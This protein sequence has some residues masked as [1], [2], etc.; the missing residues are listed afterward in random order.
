MAHLSGASNQAPSGQPGSA[1]DPRSPAALTDAPN[2]RRTPLLLAAAAGL[3]WA[4]ALLLLLLPHPELSAALNSVADERLIFSGLVVLA[5]LLTFVPAQRRL[6]L[7]GLAFEGTL[8]LWLLLYT[9]AYVPPPTGWLLSLPD[10]P[11]YLVFMLALF[12]TVAAL[13]VPLIYALGR[14]IFSQRARQYD[15]RRAR[16]Q[17]HELGALAAVCAG[18]AG[19][20]VLTPLALLILVLIVIVVEMLFLSFVEAG[21]R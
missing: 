16:R 5:A 8:G 9:L 4:A 15:L 7:P 11:V 2:S 1:G 14:W 13:T 20:R 12:L 21:T 10:T 6:E 18:M 17:A 3:C 19:L